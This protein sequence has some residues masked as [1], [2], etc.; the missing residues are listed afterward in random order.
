MGAHA[1][2]RK[3][4][5]ASIPISRN[6]PNEGKFV[7]L[8]VFFKVNSNGRLLAIVRN[9]GLPSA[10]KIFAVNSAGAFGRTV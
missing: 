2:L 7:T 3:F 5:S 10:V 1:A 8:P 6:N 9:A 4:V